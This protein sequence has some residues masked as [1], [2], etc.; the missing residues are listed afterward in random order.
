MECDYVLNVVDRPWELKEKKNQKKKLVGHVPLASRTLRPLNIGNASDANM[1][2]SFFR[3]RGFDI[4]KG[5]DQ[6]KKYGKLGG[7]ARNLKKSQINK[8]L[9]TCLDP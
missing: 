5:E 9:K 4:L 3:N 8:N 6:P 1:C 2:T 7:I